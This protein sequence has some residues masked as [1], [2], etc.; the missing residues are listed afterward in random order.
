MRV[1]FW[2]WPQARRQTFSA[3]RERTSTAIH[4]T[5]CT[6]LNDGHASSPC[7]KSAD[8]DPSLV[9]KGALNFVIVGAG[10]TGTEM[11]GAFGDMLQ[12]SLKRGTLGHKA[13]RTSPWT[14][15]R[16]SWW[17]GATRC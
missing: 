13:Y 17:M 6:M 7:S 14:G 2:C 9:A 5:P 3:H 1:T 11:A 12:S 8:R 10:A 16:L 4:C 15:G